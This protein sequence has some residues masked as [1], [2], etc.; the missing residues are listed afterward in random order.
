MISVDTNILFPALESSNPDHAK[1]SGFLH[2]LRQRDDVAVSEF[3][4]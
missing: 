4:L 2:S 3:V 1:A